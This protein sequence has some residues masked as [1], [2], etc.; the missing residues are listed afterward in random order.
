[1]GGLFSFS[2]RKTVEDNTMV[3]LSNHSRRISLDPPA[4]RSLQKCLDRIRRNVFW[5]DHGFVDA[6][7][8]IVRDKYIHEDEGT[9][10]FDWK[11]QLDDRRW[12]RY[13]IKF[14]VVCKGDPR[15]IVVSQDGD[16]YVSFD[17]YKTFS[18]LWFSP[19]R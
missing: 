12:R 15:R 19:I 16:A 9:E 10:F 6:I 2:H 18:R 4:L 11:N 5:R 8:R 1:M 14:Y 13:F 7:Q 3:T 17:H